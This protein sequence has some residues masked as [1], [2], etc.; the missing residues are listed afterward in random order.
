M[1]VTS[2]E[3]GRSDY[4][5]TVL[6]GL[7]AILPYLNGLRGDFTFDDLGIIREDRLITGASA[8]V[9]KVF[10]TAF[11]PGALY[12]PIAMLTYLANARMGCGVIG[13]HVVNVGLHA[14]VT[15]AT[16]F[17]SRILL[18]STLAA[19]LGAALFAVHPV[20]TEAVSSIVG[21]GELLAALFVLGSL[22]ALAR[23]TQHEGQQRHVWVAISAGLVA[24]GCLAKESG[25][26][27]IPLCAAVY[28]WLRRAPG[29]KESLALLVPYTVVAIGYLGL[30]ILVVGSLTLPTKPGLLDNPLAHVP[31]LPR[32]ETALVVLWQYLATL[33]MPLHLSADYSYNEIPVVASALDPR[34]LGALALFT[35]ATIGLVLCRKRAPALLLAAAFFTIPLA[36]TANVLFPI[37]TIKAERLLYLPSLGWCLACAWLISH[38]PER[39]RRGWLGLATLVIVALAGRTWVRNRDWQSNFALFTATV[40]TSPHSAKA[41]H[42][43]AVAYEERGDVDN[44]M[45]HFRAALAIYPP[46]EWAAFG[47]GKIYEEKGLENG[48]L[49]WYATA[50]RLNDH[51]TLAYLNSGAIYYKRGDLTAAERDFHSGLQAEPNNPRLLIGMALVRVA[52][53]DRVEARA[54][55]DRAESMADGT[56]DIAKL[57]GEARQLLEQKAM[58]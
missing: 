8:S 27:A 58:P 10:T 31:L 3:L 36:L 1:R 30:R 56:P 38:A 34:F 15:V 25:F 21:R 50:T 43:L 13:Y 4:R 20:H 48:A 22:F 14:L 37:G 54:L 18:D 33:A 53:D 5:L 29:W 39:H 40:Q 24:A 42:N 44:A 55:L 19:V 52:Q 7:L 47:I 28:L 2:T 46:Y 32:L 51:V 49:E 45:L 12:R 6:V 17:L 41:Q 9:A 11:N 57:L 26:V 35:A 16:F 23:A